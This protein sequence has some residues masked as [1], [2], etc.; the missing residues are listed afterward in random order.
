MKKFILGTITG[1]ALASTVALAATYIAEDA[2][3]KVF[4]NG[5]EFTS[6][7]AVV[8]DGSTYLP[9]R[10]M[11]DVLGVPVNW[12]NELRQVE[13]GN[14]EK[15]DKSVASENDYYENSTVVDVGKYFGIQCVNVEKSNGL[16]TYWYNYDDLNPY[17]KQYV[18]LLSELGYTVKE[19]NDTSNIYT[20]HFKKTGVQDF[21]LAAI[22]DEHFEFYYTVTFE[23]N[24]SK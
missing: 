11:G 21:E 5:E 12:N 22:S 7:K 9:L 1:V 23:E 2:S 6:S 17:F 3:F 16:V 24:V 15:K 14:E 13:V 19:I 18:A 8:I 4:V 10:A 20:Y